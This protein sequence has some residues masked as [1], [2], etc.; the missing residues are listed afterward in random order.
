MNHLIHHN[1]LGCRTT[2]GLNLECVLQR[3]L[4][5]AI[6]RRRIGDGGSSLDIHRSRRASPGQSKI[7]MV[8]QIEELRAELDLLRFAN[9]EVLLQD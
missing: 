6:I 9:L 8:E 1:R 5:L 4:D 7:W 3:E 2:R